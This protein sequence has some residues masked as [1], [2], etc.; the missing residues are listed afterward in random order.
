[1]WSFTQKK[2]KTSKMNKI[3]NKK[4]SKFTRQK[5]IPPLPPCETSHKKIKDPQNDKKKI[6][7]CRT[8]NISKLKK[9]QSSS[10]ENQIPPLP[11]YETLHKRNTKPLK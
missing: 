10:E 5:K 11:F 8:F 2:L 4:P 7:N 9:L 1:M 6:E 3:P